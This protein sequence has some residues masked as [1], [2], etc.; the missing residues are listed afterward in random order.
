MLVV[1]LPKQQQSMEQIE[2]IIHSHAYEAIEKGEVVSVLVMRTYPSQ[3]P[4]EEAHFDVLAKSFPENPSHDKQLTSHLIIFQDFKIKM[5][6]FDEL[7]V[8]EIIGPKAKAEEQGQVIPP[9]S[10]LPAHWV[11]EIPGVLISAFF[12]DIRHCECNTQEIPVEE[13]CHYLA[14]KRQFGGFYGKNKL[15]MVTSLRRDETGTIPFIVAVGENVSTL[16]LGRF[17]NRLVM[18]N[19]FYMAALTFLTERKNLMAKVDYFD[20]ELRKVSLEL[21]DQ[22]EK[23]S[24][25]SIYKRLTELSVQIENL[26]TQSHR[27]LHTTREYISLVK[28]LFKLIQEER[29]AEVES[30]QNFVLT[31]LE[32]IDRSNQLLMSLISS[33]NKK[34]FQQNELVRSRIDIRLEQQNQEIF[35]ELK[36]QA[37]KQIQLQE[38][39]EG[40]SVAAISYY[41]VSLLGYGLKSLPHEFLLGLSVDVWKGI[42]VPIVVIATFWSMQKIKRKFGLD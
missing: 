15:M 13:Y 25:E 26:D 4:D 41:S 6:Q 5:N 8:Y 34:V 29:L 23:Y 11:K 12:I 17:I 14:A 35:N 16:E 1:P 28:G 37:K 24:D 38:T 30:F 2:K 22:L 40:F 27:L 9:L 19:A 33:L 36:Y 18:L 42:A 20:A 39:V 21:E 7:T 32:P 10:L 31:M 3:R